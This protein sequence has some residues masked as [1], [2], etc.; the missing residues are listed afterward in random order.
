[1]SVGVIENKLRIREKQGVIRCSKRKKELYLYL[2]K[3]KV[4]EG[5]KKQLTKTPP[6]QIM[7]SEAKRKE[8]KRNLIVFYFQ[9]RRG[10][11]LKY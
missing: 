3:H 8:F 11:Y 1:M 9:S 6:E 5:G 2:L 10:L 7:H 4:K